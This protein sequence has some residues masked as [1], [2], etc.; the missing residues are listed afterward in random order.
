MANPFVSEEQELGDVGA[1]MPESGL[2]TVNYNDTKFLEE[3][4][5]LIDHINNSREQYLEEENKKNKK[6]SGVT[7][8][9]LAEITAANNRINVNFTTLVKSLQ[10][11]AVNIDDCSENSF[12]HVN[13]IAEI[14]DGKK[15]PVGF[16]SLVPKQCFSKL[17][18]LTTSLSNKMNAIVKSMVKLNIDMNQFKKNDELF[19]NELIKRFDISQT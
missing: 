8:D 17:L 11:I 19:R 6:T 4:P 5:K 1:S 2:G 7:T 13:A 10:Q 18:E 12:S 16:Q 3:D 15:P 14:L 9:D